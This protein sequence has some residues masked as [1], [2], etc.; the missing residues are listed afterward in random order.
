MRIVAGTRGS[1]LALTQTRAV[2]EA[3]R[4]FGVEATEQV[5][6]TEG[7]R[8]RTAPRGDGAFVKELQHAL[9]DG[10]VD[11]AVHSLKDVPT[12]DVPGIVLAAVPARADARECLVGSALHALP[13]RARIA[14]GSP[15]RTAQMRGLRPDAVISSIRGNV[16]TRI[17]KARDGSFDAVIL[18]YAGLERLGIVHEA[19][20]VFAF[21]MFLPAPGQG[22]LAIEARDGDPIA[23]VIARLND[24][25][26]RAATHAERTVLR[27]LG[28]GCMLPVGAYGVVRNGILSLDARVVSTDGSHDVRA[29][30]DGPAADAYDIATRVAGALEDAGAKELLGV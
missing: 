9:L 4:A 11:I 1:A 24:A 12:E 28:G 26:T 13:E 20:H 16:P 18:A 27:L 8:A 3:L 29:S 23:D 22:A 19:A 14:T 2:C 21:D 10:T 6:T 25:D 7:D 30:A 5:I 17:A 15:R